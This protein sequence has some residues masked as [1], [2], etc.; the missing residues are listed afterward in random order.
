MDYESWLSRLG[1]RFIRPGT[2]FAWWIPR[3]RGVLAR[4]GM[5]LDAVVTRL[6]EDGD[7]MRERLKAIGRVPRMSTYAV[8]AIIN[9]GVAQMPPGT[10]Y[11]NVGVWQGFSLLAG[12]A[13]NPDRRCVGVDNFSE[14]GGPREEFLARFEASRGPAHEFHDMDY[15]E[16]F[17]RR[18]AGP[19]GL[20]FYD[21]DH[22]YEHQ[23][24]GLETAEPFLVPGAFILV[25]DTNTADPRQ[26]T[27]DFAARGGYRVVFDRRTASNCHPTLWNGLMILRKDR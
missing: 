27:L 3:A 5:E 13:G 14:F 12:M 15:G 24:K 18:H 10:A 26:A 4:L 8:A 22:R 2:P 25:D 1:F 20:Y 17:A 23:L 9:R 6:P 19:I 11:V 16:Y 7:A 21:G